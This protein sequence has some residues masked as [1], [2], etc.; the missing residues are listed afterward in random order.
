MRL[1]S[2]Q[3]KKVNPVEWGIFA[4]LILIFLFL[5]CYVIAEPPQYLDI[6]ISKEI[7]ENQSLRLNN[8]MIWISWFG[9]TSI[10]VVLVISLSLALLLLQFKR[11]AILLLSTLFS[12][13]V[14]LFFK[15]LINR[16]RPSAKLVTLLEDTKFQSFP[17]G[18]VLFYTVFFGSLILMVMNTNKLNKTVKV[19]LTLICLVMIVVGAISRVYL[20]A[21]WFTDVLGGFVLGCI[22]LVIAAHFY[23]ENTG[24]I[25]NKQK[26]F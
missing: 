2:F 12:G 18:H 8:F 1:N 20:G 7:Q 23:L 6:H 10:S 16:P 13:V 4:V 26:A 22:L 11:E 15:V 3:F 21:H 25:Y 14:G 5:S 24:G 9:R 17:S 19:I